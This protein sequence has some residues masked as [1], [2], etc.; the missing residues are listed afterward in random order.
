MEL[1]VKSPGLRLVLGHLH[2]SVAVPEVF[3]E[4]DQERRRQL[5][6]FRPSSRRLRVR[7][8]I[9][10]VHPPFE[11]MERTV[12]SRDVRWVPRARFPIWAIPSGGHGACFGLSRACAV[13]LMSKQRAACFAY[14]E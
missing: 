4:G 7:G 2:D 8:R 14:S 5:V 10:I 9:S 12:A 1:L 3:D 11:S 6:R 13:T